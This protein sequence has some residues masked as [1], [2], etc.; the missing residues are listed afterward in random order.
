MRFGSHLERKLRNTIGTMDL[1]Y[2]HKVK[3][4][5]VSDNKLTFGLGRDW[6][7]PES[8]WFCFVNGRFDYDDFESWQQRA[9]A[10]A[11]PGYHLVKT[12]DIK[13]DV[14]SGLGPRREWGSENDTLKFEAAVSQSPAQSSPTAL[15]DRPG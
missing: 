9:N 2:Y 3:E 8:L 4:G 5:D 13:L 1:S 7:Y 15:S 14:R 10:Q 12:D 6:L 11:G